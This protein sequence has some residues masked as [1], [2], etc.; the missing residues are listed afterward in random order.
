MQKEI[1]YI[2]RLVATGIIVGIGISVII[3]ILKVLMGVDLSW[4]RKMLVEF[5]YSVYFGLVLTIINSTFFDY[6]NH[7]VQWNEQ[8]E[9][10]RVAI[11]FL[12][13]IPLTLMGAWLVRLTIEVGIN[14][15]SF[16]ALEAF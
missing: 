4:D 16:Q 9:K 14:Q 8:T 6:L 10:Y 5:G 2:T 15:K 3:T 12:G 1:K 7:R 13:S 11:G